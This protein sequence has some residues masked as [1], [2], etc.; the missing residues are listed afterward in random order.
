MSRPARTD[1][2]RRLFREVTERFWMLRLV[3]EVRMDGLYVRLDPFQRTFRHLPPER[4]REARATSYSAT[5]FGGWHWG[6][7]HTPGGNTVYRLRGS[8]G[9]AVVQPDGTTWFVGSQRPAEFEAALAEVATA[10]DRW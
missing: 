7:R 2:D 10:A 6:L 1:P 3:T 5:E 8:R 9:V 4:I